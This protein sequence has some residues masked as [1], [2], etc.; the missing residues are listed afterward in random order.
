M[1]VEMNIGRA[2]LS[3]CLLRVSS[4]RSDAPP[5]TQT[6]RV[7]SGKVRLE[8]SPISLR[9]PQTPVAA[10]FYPMLHSKEGDYCL[11]AAA[12]LQIFCRLVPRCTWRSCATGEQYMSMQKNLA[13]PCIS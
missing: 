4:P 7:P 12:P 3:N 6:T 11:A 1:N 9:P 5:P 13:A 2:P 8:H 10:Q